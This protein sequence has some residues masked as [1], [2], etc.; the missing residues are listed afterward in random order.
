VVLEERASRDAQEESKKGVQV[1]KKHKRGF[2]VRRQTG[3]GFF[4]TSSRQS[5]RIFNGA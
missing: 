3:P 1:V 2:T 5:P 4:G